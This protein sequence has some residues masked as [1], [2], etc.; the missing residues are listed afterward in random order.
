[1]KKNFALDSQSALKVDAAVREGDKA[2][3]SL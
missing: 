2:G 3:I 1:M